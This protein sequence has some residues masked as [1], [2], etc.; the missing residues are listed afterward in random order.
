VIDDLDALLRARP[1]DEVPDGADLLAAMLSRPDWHLEAACRGLT[2][3]LFF[4][5]RGE[6]T[7]AAK[8]VCAV[9]P[10]VDP[11]HAAAVAGDE[12]GIWAGASARKRRRADQPDIQGADEAA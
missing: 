2:A 6:R 7:D 10:V 5:A 11:C 4:P 9:C 1:G 8:A 3:A 12:E